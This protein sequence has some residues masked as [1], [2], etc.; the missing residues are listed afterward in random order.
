MK[1]VQTHM[2]TA[3]KF[4]LVRLKCSRIDL[5]I[6]YVSPFYKVATC[7]IVLKADRTRLILLWFEF[8]I[9]NQLETNNPFK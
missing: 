3:T 2:G 8:L 7:T 4:N 5:S 9:Y 1:R 6:Y